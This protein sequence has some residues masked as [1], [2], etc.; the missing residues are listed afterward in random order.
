MFNQTPP[1]GCHLPK[2]SFL[3]AIRIIK[4]DPLY[5]Q[6]ASAYKLGLDL[7]EKRENHDDYEAV[8]S[9]RMMMDELRGRVTWDGDGLRP[10]WFK[11]TDCVAR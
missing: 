9:F 10:G 11:T 8:D 6:L 3:E 2:I 1:S 5:P 7:L 4:A